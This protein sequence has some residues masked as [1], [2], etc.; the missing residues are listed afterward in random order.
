MKKV[1]HIIYQKGNTINTIEAQNTVFEA[2]EIMAKKNIGSLI[3]LKENKYQG[4][5]TERDYTQKIILKG[6]HSQETNVEEIM[7]KNVTTVKFED[8]MENCMEIMTKEHIRYLPVLSEGNV[9]GIISMG[10]VVRSIIEDQKNTIHE[11]RNFIS[12]NV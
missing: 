6:K 4:I 11:M 5:V 3:V 10:D 12:G 9:V 7:Q 2:I 8:T 1:L